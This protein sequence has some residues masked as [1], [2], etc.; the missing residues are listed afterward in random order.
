MRDAAP[1]T[2]RPRSAT[3]ICILTWVLCAALLLDAVMRAGLPG[4]RVAP[5]LVLAAVVVWALLWN[6]RVVLS[7]DRVLVRN[8]LVQHALPF[9]TIRHVRLGSMLRFDIE[10]ADGRERTITAWNAPGIGRDRPDPARGRAEAGGAGHGPSSG[11]RLGPGERLAR[12]QQ[13]SGS[14]IVVR[15]WE[16]WCDAREGAVGDSG[17]AQA[18]AHDAATTVKTR[19]N[20]AALAMLA[21]AVTAVALRLA[22]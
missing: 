1:I 5:F 22:L 9:G 14:A 21:L 19:P 18:G 20:S 11:R 2:L 17:Q 4:L 6:P 7:E 13:R 3:L 10:G 12:D 16:R 15:R 8:V